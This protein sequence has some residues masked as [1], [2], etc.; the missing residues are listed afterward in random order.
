M[1]TSKSYSLRFYA[2]RIKKTELSW[3]D[4]MILP[5][6][7]CSATPTICR[8]DYPYSSVNRLC[9]YSQSEQQSACLSVGFPLSFLIICLSS[10]DFKAVFLGTLDGTVQLAPTVGLSSIK[11]Q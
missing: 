1:L 3:D 6:L 7:V 4:Y 9:S 11:E 10:K 8:H 2:R 5:A